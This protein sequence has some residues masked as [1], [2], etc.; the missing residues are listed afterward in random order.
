M[1]LTFSRLDRQISQVIEGL[2][3]SHLSESSISELK[4]R[5]IID[6]VND[7]IYD[8][9][10]CFSNKDPAAKKS[11][12]YIFESY[13]SFQALMYYRVANA[14][15]YSCHSNGNEITHLKIV[16]RRISE[17]A[18]AKSGV[19]IHPAATIGRR[20]IIDHGYGTVIGETCE[21][22]D[23]CYI[24]QGVILGARGISGNQYSKR[25]P[26]LGNR[27]EVGGC[28]RIFGAVTIGDD[29]KIS[30]Y[31]VITEDIPANSKVLLRTTNQIIKK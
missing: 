30:P 19:E 4:T 9:L 8:D 13:L 10:I 28:V 31:I 6:Q 21:I 17:Q 12:E 5:E 24:L 26:T 2:L 7:R 23:D 27:V 18:K 20:C 29:V 22:G 3:Q 1:L 25:H 16:A 11:P 14:L 15:Y